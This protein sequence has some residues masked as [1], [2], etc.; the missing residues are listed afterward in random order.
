MKRFNTQ[1]Q[2]PF[3]PPA[4]FLGKTFAVLQHDFQRPGVEQ[5]DGLSLLETQEV[6]VRGHKLSLFCICSNP[7]PVGAISH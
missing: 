6:L 7:F 1:S 4:R 3:V 2:L 5:V